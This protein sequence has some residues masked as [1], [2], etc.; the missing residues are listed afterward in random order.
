LAKEVNINGTPAFVINGELVSGALDLD[1][2]KM[3]IAEIRKE[4][5]K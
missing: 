3:K 4:Q 1:N 5:L 2:F